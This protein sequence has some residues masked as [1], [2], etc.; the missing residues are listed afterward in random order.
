MDL[1]EQICSD[2]SPGAALDNGEELLEE[3]HAQRR[4][5]QLRSGAMQACVIL[6]VHASRGFALLILCILLAKVS[7]SHILSLRTMST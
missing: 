1:E 3:S 2:P 4:M 7:R 6:G 5:A